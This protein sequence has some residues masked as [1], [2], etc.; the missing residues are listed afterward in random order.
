MLISLLISLLII[1]VI[2]CL[3]NIDTREVVKVCIISVLIV[4]ILIKIL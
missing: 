1:I 3:L 4:G 2:C